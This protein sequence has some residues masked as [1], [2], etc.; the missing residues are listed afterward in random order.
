ML[1]FIKEDDM[2]ENTNIS[3]LRQSNFCTSAY[4]L[5]CVHAVSIN[6]NEINVHKNNYP[7]TD[8]YKN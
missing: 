2:Q 7:N 8:K 5:C 3:I 6:N 4:A 1:T